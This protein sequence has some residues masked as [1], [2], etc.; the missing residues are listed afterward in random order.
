MP[1]Y[2]YECQAC[3]ERFELL[4]KLGATNEGVTCPKC[5]AAQSERVASSFASGTRGPACSP[6]SST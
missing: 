2:E 3:G 4:Q 1:M 6:S 5:G